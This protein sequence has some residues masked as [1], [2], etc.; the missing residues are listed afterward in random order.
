MPHQSTSPSPY[1]PFYFPCPPLEAPKPNLCFQS[2][3]PQDVAGQAGDKPSLRREQSATI[4]FVSTKA[5]GPLI[6]GLN[7]EGLLQHVVEGGHTWAQNFDS[8]WDF[9]HKSATIAKKE[10]L[11]GAQEIDTLKNVLPQMAVHHKRCQPGQTLWVHLWVDH[12]LGYAKQWH[13]LGAFAAFKAE[14]R[15]ANSIQQHPTER[16][17]IPYDVV[18]ATMPRESDGFDPKFTAYLR[19]LYKECNMV[20]QCYPDKCFNI[21]RGRVCT[22]CKLG[23][24]F[25]VPQEREELDDSGVRLLYRRY[26]A[27]DACVVPHNRCLLVRL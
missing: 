3:A 10:G 18:C 27:E 21:G 6:V 9:L 17:S 26:E 11:L 15:S 12:M 7:N 8:W 1:P 22:K 25:S 2:L 16:N 24:P 14:E 5:W 23:Y 13:A 20:H 19:D 4:L